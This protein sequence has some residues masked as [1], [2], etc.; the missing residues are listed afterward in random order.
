M[1]RKARQHVFVNDGVC[2][3]A[4][5]HRVAT[6]RQIDKLVVAIAPAQ[7]VIPRA[8][9]HKIVAG[10]ARNTVVA[11]LAVE[12]VVA[13]SAHNNVSKLG[14]AVPSLVALLLHFDIE[15]HIAI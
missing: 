12:I 3:T 15:L 5:D 13:G 14:S 6:A 7:A 9:A 4:P 10:P 8:A 11:S 1:H 2:P